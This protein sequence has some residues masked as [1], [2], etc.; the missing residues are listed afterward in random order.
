MLAAQETRDPAAK[1]SFALDAKAL[2]LQV[3][4]TMLIPAD[5]TG[6]PA[7]CPASAGHSFCPL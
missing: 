6:F 1:L 4:P 5:E 2:G 7:I 3:P